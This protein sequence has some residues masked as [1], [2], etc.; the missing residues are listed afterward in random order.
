[1]M[2]LLLCCGLMVQSASGAD[3][4]RASRLQLEGDA[5][6][7]VVS[8]H[9][10]R[11]TH[12]SWFLLRAP[13]RL[14]IDLP[15]TSFAI[16]PRAAAEGKGLVS[17]IRYGHFDEDHARLI[18]GGDAPFTV[19]SVEMAPEAEEDGYRMTAVLVAASASEF[20]AALAERAGRAAGERD[21]GD[22][23]V[24]NPGARQEDRP[25]TVVLDPGHGGIDGGAR[26]VSGIQE[27]SITLAFALELRKKLQGN[28][29]IAVFMTREKDVFLRLSERVKMAREHEADLFISIH[30]DTIRYRSV[31]GA[32]VYT[33]S[34]K[35]SD[36]MAQEVAHGENLADR[37]AGIM[38]EEV[39]EEVN[40]ILV[41]LLRRET[42]TF[43][44]TFAR[45]LIGEM[46]NEIEMIKN[47]HRSAGFQVLTAPDVPSV[48]LELGYLSNP[49]DEELMRD[50]K[51]RDRAAG[52]IA[53]AIRQYKR[54]L[55]NGA[56]G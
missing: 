32:T 33:V 36:A 43:S 26:G 47:P 25:F 31:R 5:A 54:K 11:E 4:L 3:S 1:M 20:E 27:K 9:F 51:W 30:A 16:E 34:S 28:E 40:D 24:V 13:Y 15:E 22:A 52:R 39:P 56:G 38:A 53:A 14:V 17:I 37:V 19:E 55:G 48:L 8:L 41:D 45:S 12:P 21:S 23:P 10:D 29:N 18:L 35:A 50:P 6:R 46:S 49:K 42:Q 7:T 2:T 44:I